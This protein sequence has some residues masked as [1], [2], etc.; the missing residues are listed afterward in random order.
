MTAPQIQSA[1]AA[2]CEKRK[3][4]QNK[5]ISCSRNGIPDVFVVVR[6]ITYWFEVKFG[7][8][9]LSPIQKLT[10]DKLNEHQRIAFE[11]KSFDEFLKI[12]EEICQ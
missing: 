8:D 4:Y 12:M 9:K 3:I 5:T 10:I 2:W 11:I 7:K 1:I 6:G